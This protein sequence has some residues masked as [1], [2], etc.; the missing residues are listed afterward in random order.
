MRRS[1]KKYEREKN[2]Y[3]KDDKTFTQRIWKSF[4]ASNREEVL[5]GCKKYIDEL[6]AYSMELM[7]FLFSILYSLFFMVFVNIVSLDV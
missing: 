6:Y 7:Y 1:S 4:L 5:L 2:P 3:V